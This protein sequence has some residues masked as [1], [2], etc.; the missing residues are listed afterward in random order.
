MNV[1]SPKHHNRNRSHKS[2]HQP[3]PPQSSL[4][5]KL[6][7]LE[8]GQALLIEAHN[9]NSA[10]FRDSLYAL[11]ARQWMIMRALD[12]LASDTG[13]VVDWSRLERKY[14]EWLDTQQAKEQVASEHP[15][16]AVIFGG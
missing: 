8:Q 5:A 16:E 6:A 4:A 11:E 12:E 15:A 13:Q 14:R 2:E 7:G 9:A 3:K 1:R 10:A